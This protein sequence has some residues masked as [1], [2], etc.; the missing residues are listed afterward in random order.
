M[1]DM[2]DSAFATF[3]TRDVRAQYRS[4]RCG[5]TQLCCLQGRSGSAARGAA[6]DR[7]HGREA[8]RDLRVGGRPWPHPA[9]CQYPF[10]ARLTGKVRTLLIGRLVCAPLLSKRWS[11]CRRWLERLERKMG[12]TKRRKA[13]EGRLYRGMTRRPWSPPCCEMRTGF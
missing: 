1:P 9:A 12:E 11:Y 10:Q 3:R 8:Q 6:K 2:A 5:T 7:R 13:L 4:D